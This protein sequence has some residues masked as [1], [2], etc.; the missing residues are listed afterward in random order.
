MPTKPPEERLDEEVRAASSLL[1]EVEDVCVRLTAQDV[2]GQPGDGTFVKRTECD[3]GGTV[4]LE[5][6]DHRGRIGRGLRRRTPGDQPGDGR[7]GE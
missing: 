5:L 3:H 1:D 6:I 4:A 2:R 7:T